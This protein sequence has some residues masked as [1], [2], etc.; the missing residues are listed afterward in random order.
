MAD[1]LL[2][3]P[4]KI[5][6]EDIS[7]ALKKAG[8][9]IDWQVD[10]QVAID[11]ADTNLPNAIILDLILANRSGIEF[12]YE[13]R[14]YPDWQKVPIILFSSVS[15]EELSDFLGSLKH[16]NITK[17]HYKPTT[18]LSQLTQ[19]VSQITQPLSV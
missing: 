18:S 4:D 6:A 17:Y 1:V 10:P 13:F 15:V 14:S 3:E 16:L 11:N 5:L 7:K 2:I 8:H 12:L 19:S 9:N